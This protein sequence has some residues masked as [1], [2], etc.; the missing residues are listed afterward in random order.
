MPAHEAQ[1]INYLKATQVEVGF[2]FN[3]GPK[4]QFVRKVFSNSR[5]NTP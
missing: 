2:V 3:F 1:L 4:P 5:K